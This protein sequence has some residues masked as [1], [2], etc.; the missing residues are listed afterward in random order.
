[1][2][3]R[4]AVHRPPLPCRQQFDGRRWIPHLPSI[5]GR[6]SEAM[7]ATN[8]R[9]G[10]RRWRIRCGPTRW[11]VRMAA[12]RADAVTGEDGR[13]V[14]YRG[15]GRGWRW[16]CR[17][18]GVMLTRI[19][20]V[21]DLPAVAAPRARAV[22]DLRLAGTGRRRMVGTRERKLEG[23]LIFSRELLCIS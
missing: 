9:G 4:V 12:A 19:P 15:C 18:G 23:I 3:W 6:D 22:K 21:I 16:R 8:T 11:M 13:G 2:R 7:D 17:R 20:L 14:G 10:G 1:M 5:V